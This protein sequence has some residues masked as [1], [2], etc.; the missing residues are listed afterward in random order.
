VRFYGALR[1]AR[2][3]DFLKVLAAGRRSYMADRSL[4]DRA[5]DNLASKG[6]S[7]PGEVISAI[8]GLEV[9][10]WWYLKDTRA[11]SVFLHSSWEVAYG[12]LGLTDRARSIIGGSGAIIETG[13]MP[14]MGHYV[15]DG[16]ISSVLWLGPNY[17][18]DATAVL[19]N[20]RRQ[21]KFHASSAC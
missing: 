16:V 18:R 21:G 19:A 3:P 17:K 11:Y 13:F 12:V 15:T 14:Y 6:L 7:V 10:K 4:L 9:D 20:L 8:R 1:G 2:E 5:L